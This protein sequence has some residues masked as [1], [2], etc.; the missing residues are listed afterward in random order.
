MLCYNERSILTLLKKDKTM[1]KTNNLTS[2]TKEELIQELIKSRQE[3]E[4]L[5]R[6]LRRI[7]WDRQA[8]NT[9][10]ENAVRL[11]DFDARE[12]EEQ[13]MYNRMLLDAFPSI[14]IVFDNELRYVIGTGKRII[15][16]F[17]IKDITRLNH[18][19]IR[20]IFRTV[21]DKN[22][23]ERTVQNSVTVLAE[24]KTLKYNDEIE[25]SKTRKLNIG[26]T[27]S[28][29]FD[30][31]GDM[32][33]I[34]F[35]VQ[36]ITELVRVKEEAEAAAQ[37]KSN[38]LANMS[39]EIRTPMNAILAMSNLLNAAEQDE[40]K[41]SYIKNILKASDT[42]IGTIND[43]LDFSKIDAQK[44]KIVPQEYNSMDLIS[45]VT[46]IISLRAAEK[47]LAFATNIDP[48]LPCKLFG[49]DRRIK[50]VLIN[51]LSNAVKYTQ[52][53]YI[54]LSVE[55]KE[56]KNGIDIIFTIKDT[57]IG[58]KEEEIPNLFNAFSQL[59]LKKNR[60]IQGTGLGLA[61]S[62]GIAREMGGDII[63]RSTYG[64]GSAFSFR[65]RQQIKDETPVGVIREPHKKRVLVVGNNYSA[66]AL[67][68]MIGRLFVGYDHAK[69]RKEYEEFIERHSY[70]H[71]FYWQEFNFFAMQPAKLA[72]AVHTVVSTLTEITDVHK[73]KK[74]NVLYEP[75][76]VCDVAQIINE[77]HI[78]TK[79]ASS[80]SDG[81]LTRV[82]TKD[83]LALIVDDNEVNLMVAKEI[84]IQYG[85]EIHMASC[86]QEAL[87]HVKAN[88]YDLIF[89][90]HMMPNMDGLE[91]TAL[92][93]QLG[94]WNAEVPIVALTANAILGMRNIFL[95]GGMNDYVSKPIQLKELDR[96]MLTWL[97]QNKLLVKSEPEHTSSKSIQL[98][99]LGELEKLKFFDLE[100]AVAQVGGSEQTYLTIL[101]AFMRSIV[102]WEENLRTT[103]QKKAFKE[104]RAEIH[105]QKS[106]LANIGAKT[107]AEEARKLE[108][109]AIRMNV[110]Y[111]VQNAGH[112]LKGIGSLSRKLEELFPENQKVADKQAAQKEH[113]LVLKNELQEAEQLLDSLEYDLVLEKIEQLMQVSYGDEVDALLDTVMADVEN[114]EYDK[115]T[116]GMNQLFGLLN[117]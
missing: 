9:M 21:S 104:F 77:G 35:L 12:K 81:G 95:D 94:G 89:M 82:A 20:R 4:K 19:H 90:D 71:L 83:A 13:Y 14:L 16:Q 8:I 41:K 60:G 26:I 6:R 98:D 111:I 56:Q 96:V 31:A 72:G 91:T 114:F 109:A 30:K 62:K 117:S 37:A 39:H 3:Q 57:G 113:I 75:V 105:T 84:L 85:L 40:T 51:I 58:I 70:S 59:D 55:K 65:I 61:I 7:E 15:Q 44:F 11:R 66:E 42:L 33:G 17:G 101:K 18:V 48:T 36:D 68:K 49:D 2:L 110:N 1:E 24:K 87:S 116:L 25:L 79:N 27:M 69:T 97:P 10:Y 54:L 108:F 115:A 38:F 47:N 5:T 52:Q 100:N 50:Q 53:G 34:V 23:L 32:K 74:L 22:W 88:R 99:V 64:C 107:L 28:P 63:V 45:D 76:L 73:E 103:I 102:K 106:A 67:G 46:N 112:Y 43:I 78:E 80:L 86:G 92:I 93:R 29:A